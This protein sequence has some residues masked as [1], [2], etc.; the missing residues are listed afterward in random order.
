MKKEFKYF[1]MT[2]LTVSVFFMLSLTGSNN[3][4]N[5]FKVSKNLSFI[6]KDL[7]N[8]EKTLIWIS[9][10]DKG[11]NV[12]SLLSS[13]EK[14]VTQRS[15]DRRKKVK[16]LNGLVDHTDIPVNINYIN[17]LKSKGI[18]VKNKSRWFNRI[19]CYA[20]K[21]QINRIINEDYVNGVDLVMKFKK[22][23]NDVEFQPRNITPET[24]GNN[25]PNGVQYALNY[26]T[27]LTPDGGNQCTD[28]S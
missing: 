11:E 2:L 24:D 7:K 10:R 22:Q 20:D 23:Y 28:G 3:F 4:T 26:G 12:S 17:D 15:L 1:R 25:N 14:L 27:S 8:N 18:E 6:M 13:P 19:S 5:S 16:P 21:D 9:F